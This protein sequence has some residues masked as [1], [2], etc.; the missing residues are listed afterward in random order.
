M[1]CLLQA[2][3]AVIQVLHCAFIMTDSPINLPPK[4][5]NFNPQISHTPPHIRIDIE[6]LDKIFSSR[7]SATGI[8]LFLL[9]AKLDRYGDQGVRIQTAFFRKQ[10]GKNG[11]LLSKST[12]YEEKSKLQK[13]ELVDFSETDVKVR[14][15]TGYKAPERFDRR[16]NAS[17]TKAKSESSLTKQTRTEIANSRQSK[18]DLRKASPDSKFEETNGQSLEPLPDKDSTTLKKFKEAN[19]NLSQMRTLSEQERDERLLEFIVS[20]NPEAKNPRAYARTCL[21]TD[22][23]YWEQ[24]FGSSAAAINWSVHPLRE[25]YLSALK[26]N[27]RSWIG[28]CTEPIEKQQC[29]AFLKWAQGEGLL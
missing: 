15:C 28:T 27:G 20:Q 9:I 5:G 3:R 29:L 17:T 12:F 1:P 25:A 14:N 13:L 22:R 10:L 7:L 24:E 6:D 11:K 21:D 26:T 23:N 19:Q 2:D 16:E 18:A 4:D 8:K